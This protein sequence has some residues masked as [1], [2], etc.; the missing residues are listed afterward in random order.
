[1]S[2][3]TQV[4]LES[5]RI[6]LL[7]N[8]GYG[9]VLVECDGHEFHERTKQQAAYD[10][11]RDRLF[12]ARGLVTARF[13]GSEIVHYAERCCAELFE[14][15][16]TAD[17]VGMALCRNGFNPDG[18]SYRWI[19]SSALVSRTDGTLTEGHWNPGRRGVSG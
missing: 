2:L 13:T 6:D 12:A 5:Y 17:R 4:K 3:F 19:P 11:E 1:M 8:A 15:A 10:R 14:I 18:T 16:R 7:L 9:M